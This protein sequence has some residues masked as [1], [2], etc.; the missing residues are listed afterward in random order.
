[1]H[2]A[3]A[4]EAEELSSLQLL[5]LG[6]KPKEMMHTHTHTHTLYRVQELEAHLSASAAAHSAAEQQ[7][8]HMQQQLVLL[9]QEAQQQQQAT[10]ATMPLQPAEGA[11]G[12]AT[13]PL[14]A[15]QGG[16]GAPGEVQQLGEQL[17]RMQVRGHRAD[18][19]V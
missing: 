5:P 19:L 7:V 1:V 13:V 16:E 6:F 8:Q 18:K 14:A 17:E 10:D 11:K 2:V 9:Q 12:E 4:L 3:G 15:G